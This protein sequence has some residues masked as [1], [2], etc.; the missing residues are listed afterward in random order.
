MASSCFGILERN[1]LEQAMI[2]HGIDAETAWLIIADFDARVEHLRSVTQNFDRSQP[3]LSGVLD[4][5]N[6]IVVC[7]EGVFK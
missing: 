6:F 2:N 1:E 5:D 7:S 4:T 3:I